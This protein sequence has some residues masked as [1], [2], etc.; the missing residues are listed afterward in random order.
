MDKL[1]EKFNQL[2][3][4]MALKL[5]DID[6]F[7][8]NGDMDAYTAA[9]KEYAALEVKVT[10]YHE[11]ITAKQAHAD[12]NVV[13]K[14][15]EVT[16]PVKATEPVRLP[17]EQDD[18]EPEKEE[19][20]VLKSVNILRHGETEPAL[21]TIMTDMY[22]RLYQDKREA[23][24][25]AFSKYLRF[26]DSRFTLDEASALREL[27]LTPDSVRFDVKSGLTVEEIQANKVTQQEASLELGGALVPEDWRAELVKRMMGFTVVRQFARQVTTTRDVV[28]WPKLEGGDER[29]TSAVR[30]T[31]IDEVPDSATVAQT[32]FTLGTARIPIDT[33]MARL[34]ISRNLLEDAAINVPSLVSEL[35]AEEMALDEDEQFLIGVGG[36]RPYGILGVR[37]GAAY[38]P[39]TGIGNT[40]SGDASLLTADGLIDLV[41]EPDAQYLQ[42]AVMIGNKTTFRSIRK[43]KD[44]NSDY[45]WQAGIERGAPPTVLG[46]DYHMNQN[47]QAVAAGAYPLIFGDLRGYVIAD[48][49]GMTVERVTDADTVGKN[50]VAMFTRRRL[51]GTVVYPWML[52]AM[53]V[54]A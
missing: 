47:L 53:K 43:L 37:E 38:A 42:N 35:F 40:T 18:K 11:Q 36:G 9:R 17:F 48:R 4:A 45:L 51:G 6:G 31:W 19:T 3:S 22:G 21:D 32:N 16:P 1:L 7:L 20:T 14:A 44:G 27:V 29:H 25:A 24:K 8:A 46:Y 49:V 23:Q 39:Q 54:A 10:A 26:G 5:D 50:K 33:V 52:K 13:E 28:E 34:D 30:V 15:K 41:Y 12:L 2:K